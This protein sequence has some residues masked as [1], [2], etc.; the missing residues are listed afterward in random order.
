MQGIPSGGTFF[1]RLNG[2]APVL[3]KKMQPAAIDLAISLRRSHMDHLILRVE[4]ATANRRP[5]L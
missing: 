1:A 2:A 5:S 4:F 3:L